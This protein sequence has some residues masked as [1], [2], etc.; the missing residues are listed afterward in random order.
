MMVD[1]GV[2][3]D[4]IIN[5]NTGYATFQRHTAEDTLDRVT[6][7]YRTNLSTFIDNVARQAIESEIVQKLPGLLTPE[8]ASGLES[9]E[10]KELVSE[11]EAV[12]KKREQFMEIQRKMTAA[13]KIFD[14]ELANF[15]CAAV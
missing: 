7:T 2:L 4:T 9:N 10:L 14:K 8:W 15:Q 1:I 12:Q 5:S 6:A 11:P 13:I 3:R